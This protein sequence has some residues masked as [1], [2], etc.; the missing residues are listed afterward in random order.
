M[1]KKNQKEEWV[2]EYDYKYKPGD[3]YDPKVW[4]LVEDQIGPFL[5]KKVRKKSYSD[6]WAGKYY[7]GSY[8]YSS[9]TSGEYTPTEKEWYLKR[10][11]HDV[12]KIATIFDDKISLGYLNQ[13]KPKNTVSSKE[14]LIDPR[15]AL[16]SKKAFGEK[17]DYYAGDVLVNSAYRSVFSKKDRITYL[18][19]YRNL[20]QDKE[21]PEFS[22]EDKI[23]ANLFMSIESNR[24]HQ[25]IG[26]KTPGFKPYCKIRAQEK[27]GDLD[28]SITNLLGADDEEAK[29]VG[30]LC[31][32]IREIDTD[33]LIPLDVYDEDLIAAIKDSLELA[34]KCESS[35]ESL[36]LAREIYDRYQFAEIQKME[37]PMPQPSDQGRDG[38]GLGDKIKKA[39]KSM[40]GNGDQEC[41]GEVQGEKDEGS[42]FGQMF[43]PADIMNDSLTTKDL[44]GNMADAGIQELEEYL[45]GLAKSLSQHGSDYDE[46]F[47]PGPLKEWQEQESFKGFVRD[48]KPQIYPFEEYYGKKKHVVGR[49]TYLHYKNGDLLD[50]ENGVT[51]KDTAG[52]TAAYQMIKQKN[53][54][55]IEA[56]R[57]A[58]VFSNID[59]MSWEER[60]RRNGFLDE[61]G[62]EK[63]AYRSDTLFCN[64]IVESVPRVL[65]SI[66]IDQSYS[67]G[68]FGMHQAK[69]ITISMAE[70]IRPLSGVDLMVYI[71]SGGTECNIGRYITLGSSEDE[72]HKLAYMPGGCHTYDGYVIKA[73]GEEMSD[74][75]GYDRKLIFMISDG[76][77]AGPGYAGTEAIKHTNSVS[78]HLRSNLGV[79]V[80]GLGV[81][82]AY[83]TGHGLKE[84]LAEEGIYGNNKGEFLY[85]EGNAL[86]FED[87]DHTKVSTVISTF[88]GH[89][90]NQ[91]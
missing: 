14:V 65:V 61:G 77:P 23:V 34:A 55:L 83:T 21:D 91:E 64:P 79:E 89:I 2:Y 45:D 51:L 75:E 46:K 20:H 49:D 8:H 52:H 18:K 11:L 39:M 66:V 63:V 67:M 82:G 15:I 57:E 43:S 40:A 22:M 38:E 36:D 35:Q 42:G 7:N 72:Y 29:K 90:C 13:E 50:I 32:F 88:L 26:K 74:I 31:S 70:A 44:H 10:C 5:R 86:C 58:L 87:F 68:R 19:Q 25:L 48:L 78:E 41:D 76:E 85:G 1:A 9:S 73:I 4:E 24:A 84:H 16:D 33:G 81:N 47:K 59:V 54:S 6:Y 3:K 62:L 17:I 53:H 71:Q 27:V 30:E 60:G 37:M 56:M 12:S 69:E 28:E 80:Y